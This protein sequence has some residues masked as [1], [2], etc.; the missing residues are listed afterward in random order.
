[1]ISQM[2]VK[3]QNLEVAR[4][5]VRSKNLYNGD[6][7]QVGLFFVAVAVTRPSCTLQ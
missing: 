6:T 2:N 1:M 4:G 5:I 3:T 7:G